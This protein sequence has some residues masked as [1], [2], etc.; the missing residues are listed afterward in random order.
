LNLLETY[1][2]LEVTVNSHY[3]AKITCTRSKLQVISVLK[4][5]NQAMSLT[6]EL[7]KHLKTFQKQCTVIVVKSI[8]L[9]LDYYQ[10]QAVPLLLHNLYRLCKTFVTSHSPQ[11]QMNGHC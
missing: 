8:E 10:G 4:D 1:K 2:K 7:A 3:T 11:S 5:N 6:L 9:E